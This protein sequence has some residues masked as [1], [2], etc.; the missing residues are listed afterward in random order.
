[1]GKNFGPYSPKV[2]RLL[3]GG[4][5]NPDQWLN[6]PDILKE[7][8][9]LM[10]LAKVNSASI[11]IFGW[12][13]IE[14]EEGKFTFEWLDKVMDDLAKIG[15]QVVLATPSGAKPN[16]M[17]QKYPEIRR[18][19]RDGS[20]QP[21]MGRHNNC[22]HSPVYRQ[23]VTLINTKLAERYKDHPAL[24]VWHISNEYNGG[25]CHCNFCYAAFRQWLKDRYKTLDALNQAWWTSFWASSYS[26]WDQIEPLDPEVLALELDWRRFISYSCIQFFKC[27]IAPL[28][29]FTPQI[30]VTTNF[31]GTYDGL[32]YWKLAQAEDVVSWDSYPAWH[33]GDD[34]EEAMATAFAHDLNRSLKGGKP[35]M[36]MES[37]P[38]G[39][40]WREV[41]KTKKP[42]MHLA[43]SLQ[44]VA[45]GSDTVMYFQWRKGRGSFEKFHGAVVDHVGT[46][47]TRVFG[48]VTQVGSA[49]EK[50]A[51]VLGTGVDAQVALL[52]DTENRWALQLSKGPRNTQKNLEQDCFAHYKEFWRRGIP[53]D[54]VN[55]DSDISKYK[56]LVAPLMYMLTEAFA[57]KIE[58]F[59]KLGGTLVTTYHSAVVNESDL[60]HLGGRPGLIRKVLG[61]WA[62][63]T[64]VLTDIDKQTVKAAKPNPLGLKG[65]YAA[66]HY[67]D[68]VH[69]E[70]AKAL[71]H[72]GSDFY[73]KSPA[74]TLNS[75][76][77]GKGY[78]IC[79]R[80]DQAFLNDFYSGLIKTDKLRI[81]FKGSI[82]DGV[83][84]C[85]RADEKNR[86][87]FIINFRNTARVVSGVKGVDMISG[88][89]AASSLKLGPFGCVVL[90]VQ[91]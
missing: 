25:D 28:K 46:E 16:W 9:R 74:L 1:M 21:Q 18:V 11:N 73:A 89:R 15:S 85:E 78:Y 58:N 7:D 19:N 10:K 20:R 2:N 70:G 36:L 71:A 5:Y 65:S 91:N 81:P 41:G 54:M 34:A 68:I 55:L 35:F 33:L 62:E 42:G 26:S 52:F 48:E 59:V 31:M 69:L 39:T 32:D 4:D 80:N 38:E 56:V 83:E 47:H 50:L 64:D 84:I 22:F 12:S 8:L 90:K 76:G 82:P 88:K 67:A 66:R 40:N 51:P 23:K 37:T 6:Q 61:I 77:K 87:L 57:K 30:P 27:E 29:K 43:A 3:H 13:A 86:F 72:Y 14:P 45:H 24:A 49:L 79:S 60:C 53:V 44:A 75:Y 17:A 63:E